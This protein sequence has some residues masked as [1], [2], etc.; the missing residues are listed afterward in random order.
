MPYFKAGIAM[1]RCL[2][3]PLLT[4]IQAHCGK[5]WDRIC[6][7]IFGSWTMRD[8]LDDDERKVKP[9]SLLMV[10][11]AAVLGSMIIYNAMW[12]QGS[13]L[14]GQLAAIPAGATTRMDVTVP[15]EDANTVVIKY[16]PAIEDVQR[17]LLAS[18][19]FKGMVDGVN[20]QRTKSAVQQYQQENGLPVTGEVTPELISHIQY[21]RKVK[22]A[23]EFTG[24]IDPAPAVTKT[25]PNQE[26]AKDILKVQA[27]LAKLGYDIGE[28]TG[29][30]DEPTHAAILQYELENGLSM[31]GEID[32]PLLASLLK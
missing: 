24:S 22:A 14:R 3:K 30:L 18:G 19:Q 6:L 16:D 8:V 17:E 5:A 1:L 15:P 12:G 7:L 26:R 2:R 28:P 32:A 10:T 20:G 31:D 4:K 27:A 25:D 21:T 9:V 13:A 23:A 29:T 11:T